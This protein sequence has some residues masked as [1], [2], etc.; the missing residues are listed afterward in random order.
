MTGNHTDSLHCTIPDT[1]ICFLQLNNRALSAFTFRSR[2]FANGPFSIECS[3]FF[4]FC[5]F[6]NDAVWSRKKS[7]MH[8]FIN[9]FLSFLLVFFLFFFISPP[10]FSQFKEVAYLIV[11]MTVTFIAADKAVHNERQ[12]IIKCGKNR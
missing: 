6:F 10:F 7:H 11:S 5:F 1:N 2:V 12:S 9:T 3:V 4:L 8:L